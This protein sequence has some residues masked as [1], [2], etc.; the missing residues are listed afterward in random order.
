MGSGT[1][2]ELRRTASGIIENSGKHKWVAGNVQATVGAA[3]A[4]SAL[5]ATP[6]KYLKVVGDDGTTYVIP[7]YAAA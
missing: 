3:G 6:S 1:D 4:A 5:P 2:A 7:A